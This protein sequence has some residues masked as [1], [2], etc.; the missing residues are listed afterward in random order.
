MEIP[1]FALTLDTSIIEREAFRFDE[2]KLRLLRQFQSSPFKIVLASVVVRE[3]T[4]HLERDIRKLR[5]ALREADRDA[6]R[7]VPDAGEIVQ[8]EKVAAIR[9]AEEA[10]KR[11]SDYMSA[12]G[13]EEI[14]ATWANM[15]DVERRYFKT[16]PP[17]NS[18]TNKKREFP[19]AIALSSL[20]MWARSAG[21]QLIAVSGDKGWAGYDSDIITVVETITG[22]LELLLPEPEDRAVYF[23]AELIKN[24]TSAEATPY[25]AEFVRLLKLAFGNIQFSAEAES[26][27]AAVTDYPEVNLADFEITPE[28]SIVQ[29]KV[30]EII[31]NMTSRITAQASVQVDFS[32]WDGVDKEDIPMGSEVF[33]RDLEFEDADLLVTFEGDFT[34]DEWSISGVEVSN[35]NVQIDLGYVEPDWRGPDDDDPLNSEEP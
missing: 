8:R 24:L 11:L 4:G 5:N 26:D 15:T 30:N 21:K 2:G 7:L 9:P 19:D 17:F 20:E 18:Q 27:M 16:L 25:A 1:E 28:F 22:A 33:S 6:T 31:V 13:A 12:V 3:V 23:V 35:I 29:V 32:V 10:A 14:G 34:G